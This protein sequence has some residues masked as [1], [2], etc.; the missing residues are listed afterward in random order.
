M[1]WRQGEVGG[2]DDGGR[3]GRQGEIMEVGDGEM[4]DRSRWGRLWRQG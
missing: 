3:G 4:M 1:R 2:G